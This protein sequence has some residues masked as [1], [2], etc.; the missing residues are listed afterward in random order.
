MS[1]LRR[2]EPKSV[3]VV[4]DTSVLQMIISMQ[5]KKLGMICHIVSDGIAAVEASMKYEYSIILM[6]CQ[7]PDMDGYEATK[8]IR[9]HEKTIGRHIP[10][11]A[12]TADVMQGTKE[13]CIQ[14]GMDDYLS[15]PINSNQLRQILE[16]WLLSENDEIAKKKEGEMGQDMIIKDPVINMK[17]I[18]ELQVMLGDDREMVKEII[19]DYLENVGENSGNLH[20]AF[21]MRNL[22]D[23]KEIAHQMRSPSAY[24]GAEQLSSIFG[25]IEESADRQDEERISYFMGIIDEEINKV[26]AE[27]KKM[28]E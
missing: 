11:I 24:L 12:L 9:E 1:I 14:A 6:D 13:K 18:T 28:M 17:K 25:I 23:I 4:E 15:K 20:K 3:L 16:K 22:V 10:I 5:L 8:L 21:K 19:R 26:E 27:L 7:M 2:K